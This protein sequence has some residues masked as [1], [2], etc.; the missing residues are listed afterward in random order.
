[1]AVIITLY[2]TGD[3]IAKYD[4]L[5][6]TGNNDQSVLTLNGA[7]AL[8]THLDVFRIEVRQHNGAEAFQNGQWV[9]IYNPRGE[10]VAE[11][12]NPRHDE[13]QQRAASNHHQVFTDQRIVFDLDGTFG[14]YDGP[15][16]GKLPFKGLMSAP[17]FLIGTVIDGVPVEHI[18]AGD[19]LMS[20]AGRVEVRYVKRHT[21]T[22]GMFM[23]RETGLIVTGQHR[24]F[25]KDGLVRAKQHPFFDPFH[26]GKA[27]EVVSIFTERHCILI[28]DGCAAESSFPGPMLRQ[29]LGPKETERMTAALGDLDAYCANKAA[30]FLNAQFQVMKEKANA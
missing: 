17:C 16:G 14:P 22:D 9:A 3:K 23:C 27:H 29:L 19:T 13:Y 11:W 18:R 20:S 5:T 6:F 1:M 10:L 21:T 28:A 15:R 12:M 25:F 24:I 8:G 2:L 26:H 4:S 30:P 7:Q